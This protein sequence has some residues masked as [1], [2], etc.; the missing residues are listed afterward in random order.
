MPIKKAKQRYH[1][2]GS[3]ILLGILGTGL[4]TLLTFSFVL[5]KV[6]TDADE[7][8]LR[9]TAEAVLQP[10][11]GLAT[12]AVNGSNVMKLRGRDAQFLYASSGLKYLAIVGTS[13]GAPK[14]AFGE[15]RPP[16]PVAY[17]FIGNGVDGEAM[18][19]LAANVQQTLIDEEGWNYVV[20][21]TLPDVTN[22]GEILAVF[23]AQSLQGSVWRTV[24]QVAVVAFVVMGLTLGGGSL[25]VAG[26]QGLLWQ[27]QKGSRRSV[28][29]WICR[30]V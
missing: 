9:E 15:A 12:R 8:R 21:R 16:S 14:S 3:T 22:G 5:Y 10:I 19:R 30:R 25:S 7:V 26:S 28:I 20:R 1:S 4:A 27:P 13:K 29:H 17:T 18:K 23:S 11:I 2:L 24:K 6:Q